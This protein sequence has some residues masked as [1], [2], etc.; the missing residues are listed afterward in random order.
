MASYS[1]EFINV[2]ESKSNRLEE[3]NN[4]HFCCFDPPLEFQ[5]CLKAQRFIKKIDEAL[6]F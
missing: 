6:D 3:I 1:N 4:F 5:G 2:S